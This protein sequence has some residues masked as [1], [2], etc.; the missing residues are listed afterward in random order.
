MRNADRREN[1]LTLAIISIVILS[2]LFFAT[3]KKLIDDGDISTF[4]SLVLSFVMLLALLGVP[5]LYIS[6]TIANMQ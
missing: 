4:T 1:V 5:I 3:I 6:L 2:T